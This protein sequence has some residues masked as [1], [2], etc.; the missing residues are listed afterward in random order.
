MTHNTITRRSFL[1]HATVGL[2]AAAMMPGVH[3]TPAQRPRNVLFICV[4][5]LRPQL[6]CYG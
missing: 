1:Q 3:A 5:D 2:S 4:D 6:P